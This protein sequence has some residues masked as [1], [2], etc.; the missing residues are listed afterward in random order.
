MKTK[1]ILAVVLSAVMLI[2]STTTILA[3]EPTIEFGG[4]EFTRSEFIEIFTDGAILNGQ[5]V[6]ATVFFDYFYTAQNEGRV[7]NTPPRNQ[8]PIQPTTQAA[9]TEDETERE[10]TSVLFEEVTLL[11]SVELLTLIETAPIHQDTRSVT[12][13]PNR[14]ITNTELETWIEE[15]KELGGI[16][17]FELEVIRLINEIRAEHDLHPLMICQQTSMAAR[18]HS[19]YQADMGGR[20]FHISPNH[21]G[22]V[23]RMRMFGNERGLGENVHGGAYTPQRAVDGWMNSPGHRALVLNTTVRTI[24]IGTVHTDHWN[25]AGRTTAKFGF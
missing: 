9:P 24:G 25:G 10:V 5:M 2:G 1:R 4:M 21:G 12:T 11:T 6:T 22:S 7:Y 16:N 14:Q 17:A 8:A 19:Q 3:S 23:A 20:I 13:L 15:Y 18:F